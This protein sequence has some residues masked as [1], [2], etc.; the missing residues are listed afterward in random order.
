MII[1][2]YVLY[3]IVAALTLTY[4]LRTVRAAR[5]AKDLT[6]SEAQDEAQIKAQF[7]T[8]KTGSERLYKLE[9]VNAALTILLVVTGLFVQ[10]M[11]NQESIERLVRRL[12]KISSEQEQM[13]NKQ[14]TEFDKQA[15]EQTK[16]NEQLMTSNEQLMTNLVQA[17]DIA[18]NQEKH[19]EKLKQ[20]QKSLQGILARQS[21]ELSLLNRLPLN[22][23]FLG[24]EISFTPSNTQWR[25][26]VSAY[27]E[28]EA[29]ELKSPE[30]NLRFE[31][32]PMIAE[33]D[34]DHWQIDFE[35]ALVK[36]KNPNYPLPEEGYK[37]LHR[38]SSKNYPL[39]DSVLKRALLGLTIEWSNNTKTV[40]D[41]VQDYYPSAIYVSQHKIKFFL[42]PPQLLLTLNEL[43][44]NPRIKFYGTDY[45]LSPEYPLDLPK[46]FTIRSLDP[47]VELEQ[48]IQ[49]DWANRKSSEPQSYDKSL[50]PK[51]SGPH[52][53]GVKFHQFDPVSGRGSLRPPETI[54]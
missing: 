41:P 13:S 16:I 48:T 10:R 15:R 4:S 36:T 43:Y 8:Q 24:I 33:S 53:L 29:R 20:Q 6:P 11:A 44:D 51:V 27:R 17:K 47:G 14:Q 49:L 3:A 28:I 34:G 40:F 30:G 9:R 1:F 45:S 12:E 23:N 22:R 42:R 18:K 25:Q 31:N 37:K 5:I 52:V 26:I 7:E 2:L 39:F 32:A 35:P 38:L 21:G 54:K 50:H 46:E 19:T